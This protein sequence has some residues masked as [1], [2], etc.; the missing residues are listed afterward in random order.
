[1]LNRK[2]G[3]QYATPLW[4]QSLE[5]GTTGIPLNRLS[6]SR[7][8]RDAATPYDEAWLQHLLYRH[9]EAL[10]IMELEPG[11]GEPVAVGLEM[12]T[13]AGYVDNVFVTRT[14]NI[15]FGECKLWLNP[16][17]RRHVIAQIIDYAQ[18]ISRWGYADFD[19]AIRKSRD[20][21]GKVLNQPLVE[22]LNQ[23]QGDQEELDEAT[24]VDAIQ[25]NLRLGRLLLLVSGDGIREDTERLT[26][27]LQMHAGFHFTLALVEIAVFRGP[28]EGYVVQPRILARTLNIE[29]AVVRLA[30][31]AIIAVPE[32]RQKP[33]IPGNLSKDL[34]YGELETAS[35]ET[36]RLLSS[37]EAEAAEHG[38][39]L[40]FHAKS[41]SLKWECPQGR[42]LN[43]GGVDLAGKLVTYSVGLTPRAM[44]NV[45]LAHDYLFALSQILGGKVR[46][47]PDPGSWCIEKSG[48]PLPP[49]IE[50]LRKK[51][52][53]LNA[54][55]AY[56]A[57][58]GE[59]ED[60]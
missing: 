32:E 16:Q 8:K 23:A 21:Q 54:I 58:F 43:L 50:L 51:D 3:S 44:G 37:F 4:L 26:E 30:S 9:P 6:F 18:S 29:R 41:A 56:Q 45:Q 48:T 28:G 34:F 53:W 33:P 22:I 49:A 39:F 57:Q 40:H 13:P 36:A 17:A 12:P 52:Q 27:F 46:Q 38:V 55:S 47:T 11:I 2:G 35:P 60:A 31:D 19:A 59:A 15:V 1:M 14:G 10:P 24:F 5:R 42:I 20:A 25:M 7:K